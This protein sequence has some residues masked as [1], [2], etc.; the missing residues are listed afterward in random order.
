MPTPS[1]HRKTAGGDGRWMYHDLYDAAYTERCQ[2]EFSSDLMP[3]MIDALTK[4]INADAQ[5]NI[6]MTYPEIGLIT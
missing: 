5:L 3:S 4:V 2:I 6:V 1:V